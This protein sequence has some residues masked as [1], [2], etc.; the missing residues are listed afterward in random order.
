MRMIRRLEL[1]LE[2]ERRGILPD[3]KKG[4]LAVYRDS[5]ASCQPAQVEGLDPQNLKNLAA[6]EQKIQGMERSQD[7]VTWRGVPQNPT[8]GSGKRFVEGLV[9]KFRSSR[10]DPGCCQSH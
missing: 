7:P 4:L 8:A 9:K 6:T 5:A 2:A 10:P 3:N 1:L